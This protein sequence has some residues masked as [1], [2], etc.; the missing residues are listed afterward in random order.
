M[1][2]MKKAQ[3]GRL[4]SAWS[5]TKVPGIAG[6]LFIQRHPRIRLC[7]AVGMRG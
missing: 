3:T 6:A 7:R 2:K 5:Q 4:N 1:K